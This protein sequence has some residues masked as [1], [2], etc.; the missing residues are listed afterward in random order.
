M[1][2]DIVIFVLAMMALIKGADYVIDEAEK[3]AVHFGIPSFIIGATV[4]ALG[5][6]LPEMVASVF[7]S[8][9]GHSELAV[10]NVIGSNII[11]LSLVLGVVFIIGKRLVPK[12]DIF[13]EDSAWALFPILSFILIAY[14]GVVSRFEGFIYLLMMVAYLVFLKNNAID[15]LDVEDEDKNTTFDFIKTARFLIVGFVFVIIGADF[16][17]ESASNIARS[18]GISEWVIGLLLVS[19]GTSLPELVVSVQAAK[20]GD[21][22]MAI[23]N[24]IGSNIANF[25]VV[26]GASAVVNP[27]TINLQTTMFDILTALLLTVMLVFVAVDKLYNRS[28]GIVF[29]LILML[30][31][32]HSV[33][34]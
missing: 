6:S 1:I 23:G 21:A 13:K 29:I 17:V 26:I 31:I 27:L 8:Y 9:K 28:T 20:R 12:R 10:S 30:V 5:T 24:V 15:K 22:D 7:A 14:D 16:A 2:V 32:N 4:V 19:F 34:I 25:T 18:F 3:I 11:N 33:G